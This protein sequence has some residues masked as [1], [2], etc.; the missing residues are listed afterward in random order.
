MSGKLTTT[1]TTNDVEVC[2]EVYF[3]WLSVATTLGY[4]TVCSVRTVCHLFV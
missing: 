1:M 4:S 3:S 2:V